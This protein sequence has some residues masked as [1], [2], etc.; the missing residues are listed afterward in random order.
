MLTNSFSE[1]QF[2][3][4]FRFCSSFFSF[5]SLVCLLRLPTCLP[6]LP[7]GFFFLSFIFFCQVVS[8]KSCEIAVL[9]LLIFSAVFLLFSVINYLPKL[10]PFQARS[11]R[12]KPRPT[13]PTAHKIGH[14]ALTDHYGSHRACTTGWLALIEVSWHT[15][16]LFIHVR[17]EPCISG[18]T[19]K[20]SQRKRTMERRSRLGHGITTTK[21]YAADR[22]QL[23]QRPGTLKLGFLGEQCPGSVLLGALL[24]HV[25]FYPC[26]FV[27]PILNPRP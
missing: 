22:F 15:F 23:R 24:S 6:A 16:L 5:Y 10:R 12:I 7:S 13:S 14:E 27:F 2:L 4:Q 11:V 19:L 21:A 1:L 3:P 18:F 17:S 26:V 20:P 8:D 9:C 25:F